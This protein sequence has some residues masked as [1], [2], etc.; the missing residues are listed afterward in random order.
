MNWKVPTNA[1]RRGGREGGREG[2]RGGQKEGLVR[3]VEGTHESLK[4]EGRK[5]G[6]VRK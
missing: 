6:M 5:K 4:E 2:G 1:W 3:E